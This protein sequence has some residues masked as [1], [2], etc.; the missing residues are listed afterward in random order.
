MI[1]D[2]EIKKLLGQS[3]TEYANFLKHSKSD[4]LAE[5]GELLWECFRTDIAQVTNT[6][7]DD[8]NALIAAAN[9]MGEPF[10]ELFFHCY[11]FHSWYLGGGV[12]ND[13]ETEKKLYEKSVKSLERIMMKRKN[14]R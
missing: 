1:D 3:K 8:I 13:F 10:N 12:P 2:N 5:A 7:I 11:H 14:N 4:D 6:K 9:Q